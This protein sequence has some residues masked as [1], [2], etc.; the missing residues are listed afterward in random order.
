MIVLVLREGESVELFLPRAGGAALRA[1]Y[2]E[3]HFGALKL[4]AC[5]VLKSHLRIEER[6]TCQIDV[7]PEVSS[8]PMERSAR[9]MYT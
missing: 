7:L 3:L 9:G 2:E 8:F 4:S 5:A 1:A 6:H